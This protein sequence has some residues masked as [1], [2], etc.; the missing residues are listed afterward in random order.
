MIIFCS[1]TSKHYIHCK[2]KV[3]PNDR[4]TFQIAENRMGHFQSLFSLKEC[5]SI[6]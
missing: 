5:A 6:G 4:M 2:E 1:L 3:E